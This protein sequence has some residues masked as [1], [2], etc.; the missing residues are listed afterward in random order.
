MLGTGVILLNISSALAQVTPTPLDSCAGYNDVL[1]TDQYCEAIQYV[2]D[3]SIFSGSYTISEYVSGEKSFHPTNNINR[4]E[5]LKVILRAGGD[6]TAYDKITTYGN[7]VGFSDIAPETSDWWLGFLK[8]AKSAGIIRGYGDGT[9][10]AV[11]PVSRAE[12]LK[13]LLEASPSKN[14]VHSWEINPTIELWADTPI[15]AWYAQYIA[16][17][18]HYGL[19]AKLQSCEWGKICPERAMLRSEAAQMIFNYKTYLKID[20]GINN[21]ISCVDVGGTYNATVNPPTHCCS[22]LISYFPVYS[23]DQLLLGAGGTCLAYDADLE[24]AL[25]I[26]NTKND[27]TTHADLGQSTTDLPYKNQNFNGYSFPMQSFKAGCGARCDVDL[28]TNTATIGWMC[29]GLLTN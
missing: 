29:T 27:C 19:F 10:K 23:K 15:T 20:L 3:R 5:V 25:S 28:D 8:Q 22:G 11:N 4:A 24:K 7:E 12:F 26:Y 6:A 9:F 21:E 2:T 13:M 18:N 16:F 14:A 17:A 1:A